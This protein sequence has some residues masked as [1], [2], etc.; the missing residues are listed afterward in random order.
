MI[1]ELKV[2]LDV[3]NHP[4]VVSFVTAQR[5]GAFRFYQAGKPNSLRFNIRDTNSNQLQI[6]MIFHEPVT[7]LAHAVDCFVA[8]VH[9]AFPQHGLAITQEI[10]SQFNAS[11]P[12][13]I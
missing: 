10:Q 11:Q 7:L 8:H 2:F 1:S 12:N 4:A 9:Q 3:A 13:L 5:M 6:V